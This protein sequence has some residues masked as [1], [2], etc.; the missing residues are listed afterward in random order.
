MEETKGEW[1]MINRED[2]LELTRRMTTSRTSMRRIAG[3]YM[4][5]EGYIDG[6]FN[7]NFLKLKMNE[8]QKNLDIAKAIPFSDTNANLKDYAFGTRGTG[9][10]TNS[11]GDMRQLLEGMRRCELKNDALMETFY[12]VIAEHYQF[13]QEYAIYV[14]Y[15]VYDVPVKA[16]DK[17]RLGESEEVY[18]Y[19]ICAVCPLYDE[20]TPGAPNWGFIYPLFCDRAGNSRRIGIFNSDKD[21]TCK[22]L[23]ELL[24]NIK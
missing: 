2:M 10:Q 15:D 24:L 12:E 8:R 20:Y 5:D 14:F 22:E 7:T 18:D 9:M 6:T 4:D 16:S 1:N 13:E 11:G 19:M 23:E 3:C 21:N 17:E